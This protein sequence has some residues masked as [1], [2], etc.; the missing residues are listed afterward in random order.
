MIYWPINT[1]AKQLGE[2]PRQRHVEEVMIYA[3]KDIFSG[4]WKLGKKRKT[5]KEPT[6]LL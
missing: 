1:T 4:Q 2:W 5:A 3:N 6:S